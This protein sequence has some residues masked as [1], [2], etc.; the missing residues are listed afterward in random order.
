MRIYTNGTNPEML[1]QL[2]DK[3]LID[4][5]AMDIKAPLTEN[6]YEAITNVKGILEKVKKSVALIMNSDLGYEFR[7]TVVPSLHSEK[8]IEEIAKYVKD[9]NLLVLQKFLPENALDNKLKKLKTQNDEEMEKLA[10]I[11]RKYVK[12]VSWR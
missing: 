2:I 8:D 4:S 3:K 11:A 12:N 10:N 1:K 7:T 6:S 5:I 9:A